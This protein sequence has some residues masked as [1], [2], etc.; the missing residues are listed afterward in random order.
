MAA[1]SSFLSD[2]RLGLRVDHRRA[3]ELARAAAESGSAH[4]M[5]GLAFAYWKGL[6]VSQDIEMAAAWWERGAEL[7]D[8]MAQYHLGLRTLLGEGVPKDLRKGTRW[9]EQSAS[10][11]FWAASLHLA[12]TYDHGWYGVERSTVLARSWYERAADL[13]VAEAKGWLLAHPARR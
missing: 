3:L 10:Q 5:H 13:G 2:G 7:G 8:H 4:A 12:R 6:G 9:L 1:L 11:G